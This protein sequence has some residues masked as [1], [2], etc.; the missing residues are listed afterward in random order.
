MNHALRI[1]YGV[2]GST[3]SYEYAPLGV[4]LI[5]K[6]TPRI[7]NDER[8]LMVEAIDQWKRFQYTKL[9]N[10]RRFSAGSNLLSVFTGLLDLT[11]V[12]NF[13]IHSDAAGV[14]L[15]PSPSADLNLKRGTSL[16]DCWAILAED[17]GWN[18]YFDADGVFHALPI[19][20]PSTQPSLLTLADTDPSFNAIEG[21]FEDS[22]DIINHVG[23]ASTNPDIAPIYAEAMDNNPLS[24][25][26]VKSSFGDR[27]FE[28]EGGF[29]QSQAQAA[30]VAQNILR[31]KLY[32]SR[33]YSVKHTPLPHLDAMDRINLTAVDVQITQLKSIVES[34]SIPLSDGYQ[35][36]KFLEA[37]AIE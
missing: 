31:R 16:A 5:N 34:M 32:Y 11:G 37:R 9:L 3:G 27:F 1:S 20:D 28:Y 19:F 25:T 4:F 2:L 26:Y 36:T 14:F 10:H 22:P 8:V 13:Q 6:A 29:I 33:G 24:P 30:Q 17:F 21:G 18:F 23:V 12:Q 15:R 35:T 7:S